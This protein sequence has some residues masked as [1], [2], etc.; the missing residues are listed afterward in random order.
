MLK[1]QVGKCVKISSFFVS[2]PWGFNSDNIFFNIAAEFETELQP[3]ELLEVTQQIEQVIGRTHKTENRK[4]AD[5]IIDID[6]LFYDNQIIDS[7][8]LTI[9]HCLLHK[10]DFVLYPLAEIAPEFQH[11]VLKKTI[12]EI[13]DSNHKSTQ[14]KRVFIKEQP[15][16]FSK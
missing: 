6:I 13:I 8:Q 14:K 9:P 1:K 10:R 7:H 15:S 4:Y 16:S 2:E 11:P 12:K 5:R 3:F